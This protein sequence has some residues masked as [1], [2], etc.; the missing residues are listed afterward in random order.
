MLYRLL[1]PSQPERNGFRR[2]ATVPKRYGRGNT[3]GMSDQAFKV[4]SMIV[5]GIG[6]RQHTGVA[7]LGDN[8]CRGE[9]DGGRGG[10]GLLVTGQRL[11]RGKMQSLGPNEDA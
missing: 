9:V 4:A 2:D 8:G 7:K 3:C 11:R 1:R 6:I 5:S 10:Q